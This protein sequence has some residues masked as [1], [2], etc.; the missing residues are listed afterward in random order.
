MNRTAIVALCCWLVPAAAGIAQDPAPP[1]PAKAQADP[2][3]ELVTRMKSAE[4]ALPS[5]ALE[6]ETSGAF[7]GGM[8]FK[9]KGALRVLRG[10]Q[11]ATHMRMEFESD[12]GLHS[13]SEAAQ[14]AA[15]IVLFED[16]PANGAVYVQFDPR[17]VTDLEW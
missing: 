4:Q 17:L 14:T 5:I 8:K 3:D 2:I 6:L 13:V 9:T 16:D 7:G 15:G 10:T 12:D 1:P 11:P